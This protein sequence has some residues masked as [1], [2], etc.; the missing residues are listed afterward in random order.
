[1]TIRRS[2]LIAV[3]FA[4]PLYAQAFDAAGFFGRHYAADAASPTRG[5][6]TLALNE[7]PPDR[8]G[9]SGSGAGRARACFEFSKD[10]LRI[11]P[12]GEHGTCEALIDIG[13]SGATTSVKLLELEKGGTFAWHLRDLADAERAWL[14]EISHQHSGEWLLRMRVRKG[15]RYV[16]IQDARCEIPS[17]NLPIEFKLTIQA[18]TLS[19]EIGAASC[20]ADADLADGVSVGLAATDEPAKLA[21]L[22]MECILHPSWMQD[23]SARLA[24][25]RTLERLREHATTGLLSGIVESPHPELKRTLESY[26]DAQRREREQAVGAA[27]RAEVLARIA[28]QHIGSAAAQHEAGVSL[29][30]AGQAAAGL[31]RLVAADKLSRVPVTSL[32][33]A[34]AYRRVG[35]LDGASR[36]LELAGKDLP[37]PLQPGF[38]LIEGRLLAERGDIAGARRVLVAAR[39]K[40]E[41]QPELDAFADSAEVLLQPP[42]L[43][44]TKLAAPLGLTLISDLPEEV[45]RPLL[46]QLEPYLERIRQWL[47][48]LARQVDGVIAIFNSPVEYLRAALLVAGENLDNVAGMHIAAGIGGKSTVMV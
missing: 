37:G 1:L 47:P 20:K 3:L 40:Y 13:V 48:D 26:T 24:A 22:R 30:L 31:T 17:L 42:T 11:S 7:A 14:V 44:A 41:G 34:E 19:A 8:V 32:A 12:N 28:D 5:T 29:M 38:A 45:L 2:I 9:L 23:A 46:A 27:E 39:D 25:R 36:A 10:G 21:A 35:D 16:A 33:L 6:L 18:D 15:G 4:A 43:T